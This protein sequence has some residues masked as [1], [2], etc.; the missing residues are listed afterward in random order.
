MSSDKPTKSFTITYNANGG[1]VSVP[2]K[3]LNCGFRN[4]NT[5]SDGSGKAYAPGGTYSANESATLYA[6]WNNPRA[7]TLA[8]P[9]RSGCKFLGWY[10]SASGGTRIDSAT[11]ITKDIT[12][13]AHWKI[14][15]KYTVNYDAVGGDGAPSAQTKI[16]DAGLTLSADKP[17]KSFT[18]TY[19]ANGGSVSVPDK[20]LNCGFRNWNT[21]SDG[22]GKAYA[23]GGTYSVNESATLY[24]QWNNPRAATLATPKRVGYEFVGWF[25][26]A[27]GGTQ[28]DSDTE[29]T[30]NMMVYARWKS[31]GSGIVTLKG[32]VNGD[33]KI[34]NKDVVALFR[35]VSSGESGADMDVYDFNGDGKINNKDVVALFRYVSSL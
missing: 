7:A 19:N 21:K 5:K 30:G 18:I 35:Y 16:E 2:D 26:S 34:N 14:E 13:Y 3:T 23:P 4:W 10:T 33:G 25:T 20:T 8:T 11:E 31:D 12:V 29:I 6:Q 1:S 27:S 9:K 24:A 28:V 22:S 32:D 15:E 17:T